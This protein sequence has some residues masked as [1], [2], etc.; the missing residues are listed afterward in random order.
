M[1]K[2]YFVTSNPRK[3]SEAKKYLSPLDIE[4]EQL[5]IPY[6]EIQGSNLEE[7]ALFGI[8]WILNENE[9]EGA[10]M[11]EDA[12]LFV[13]SLSDFPGVYS[14]FVFSTIGCE[15]VLRLLEGRED[16]DAHFEAA[17]AYCE[18]GGQPL[19]FKGR[20]DGEIAN[21]PRGENGFGYDPIFVPEGEKLT[22]AE[23]QIE[24]KNQLSHRA[25]VLEKLAE[26]L[27]KR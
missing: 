23:M 3:L 1:R 13:H 24:E 10:V 26:F 25:R 2:I 27:R 5:K 21:Q 16:R 6:P 17:V 7:V 8:N 12:G 19:M 15:G 4:V 14:K 18:K 20:V 22:F 11:I 9:L